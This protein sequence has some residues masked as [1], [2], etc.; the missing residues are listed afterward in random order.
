MLFRSVI[1]RDIKPQNI[2]LGRNGSIYLIDFG[3]AREQKRQRRQDT[4]IIL[5]LD[6]A[7]PEQ[8][9]FEQTTPL[10]DIYSLGVIILYLATGQT[11]R[12]DLESQI[13][14]NRLR[15]LIEE[16]IAFNPKARIQSAAELLKHLRMEKESPAVKR[17]RIV[18]IG[19]AHV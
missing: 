3:I 2:I 7:S 5:T 17:K 6:Y 19:R 13:T 10:S 9:G 4:Y 15:E 11:I 18:K 12:S 8:Y 14:N 1:H 16:C